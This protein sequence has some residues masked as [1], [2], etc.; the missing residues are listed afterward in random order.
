M[1]HLV[2]LLWQIFRNEIIEPLFLAEIICRL[3]FTAPAWRIKETNKGYGEVQYRP[4]SPGTEIRS[5][6]KWLIPDILVS[7][8]ITFIIWISMKVMVELKK[9]PS[10]KRISTI[11]EL[12][13]VTVIKNWKGLSLSFYSSLVISSDDTCARGITKWVHGE[14]EEID[15]H[16]CT[17]VNS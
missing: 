4:G 16:M 9:R 11:F 2:A 13:I 15:V 17:Y 6:L 8:N 3:Q 12:M 7:K 10:L 14:L 1:R 5:W